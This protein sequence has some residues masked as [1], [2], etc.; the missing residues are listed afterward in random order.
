MYIL[1]KKAGD[2]YIGR[3]LSGLLVMSHLFTASHPQFTCLKSGDE[4]DS[5]FTSHQNMLQVQVSEAI[6]LIFPGVSLAAR[7][8]PT[9]QVC[10]A[11]LYLNLQWLQDNVLEGTEV[12][13]SPLFCTEKAGSLNKEVKCFLPG[14]GGGHCYLQCATANAIKNIIQEELL[15]VRE[16]IEQAN[17]RSTEVIREQEEEIYDEPIDGEHAVP[18]LVP[19]QQGNQSLIAAASE[20]S[21]YWPHQELLTGS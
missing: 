14:D 19:L 8:L 16:A 10:L 6:T 7:I 15:P 9:L 4:N 20:C 3:I 2:H 11:S 18:A 21:R 17:N 13:S 1:Y 5:N 12:R